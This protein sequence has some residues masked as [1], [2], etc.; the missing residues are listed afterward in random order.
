MT[1]KI[2]I[3]ALAVLFLTQLFGQNKNETKLEHYKQLVAILDTVHREDQEYR[4]KSST[5]EK[6]YGWDSNEMNDLWKIINEKDSIN[7]LKVTKILDNDGWLGADKIGEAGNKTLFLV[8]QHSNTQTQLKYLPMLQNAVMKGDAKPNYLALLQ[9]RVLLAQGKKQIYG[10]QLETDIKT[11][12]YVLSPMIDPDNVDKRRAQ[13]GLQPI[14]EYLKR[15]NL[16]WNVEE[17]KKR[18][19]EIEIKKEK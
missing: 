19:S 5:I 2:L 11:G 1:H 7:L 14:S 13:V 12:E 16:T 8:I 6:E 9:D 3:T 4:E 10:S 15:W 18:M 17:F